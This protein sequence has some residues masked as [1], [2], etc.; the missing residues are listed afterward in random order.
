MS[1]L[2]KKKE[3]PACRY[4][5]RV[6]YVRLHGKAKSGIVRYRCLACKRSF[7]IKYIYE[8]YKE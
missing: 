7:Q 4:C 1:Y 5:G 2:L 6:E 8:A 3:R